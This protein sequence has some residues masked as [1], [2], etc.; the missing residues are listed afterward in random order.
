MGARMTSPTGMIG[1]AIVGLQQQVDRLVTA[2]AGEGANLRA[3]RKTRRFIGVAGLI[4]ANVWLG[5]WIGHG[6][7]AL[8]GAGF[9]FLVAFYDGE[10]A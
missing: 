10:T 6:V 9:F 2:L 4:A 1:D 7:A 3:R 5:D 8:L